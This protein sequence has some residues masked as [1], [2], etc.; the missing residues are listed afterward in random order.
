MLLAPVL[1]SPCAADLPTRD[2]WKD[3]GANAYLL[4]GDCSEEGGT[5]PLVNFGYLFADP[6]ELAKAFGVPDRAEAV[7][8]EYRKRLDAVAEKIK[9]KKSLRMWIYGG[10]KTP[11]AFG[12][13]Q[14]VDALESMVEQ[15][16]ALR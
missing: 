4:A 9:G 7:I 3:F 15:L 11:Y 10:E 5:K 6:R 13:P 12:G 14:N 16:E 8:A 2:G 1:L